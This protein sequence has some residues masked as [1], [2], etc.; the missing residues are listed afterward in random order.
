MNEIAWNWSINSLQA[1]RSQR[2]LGGTAN[3]HPL[4]GQR[5]GSRQPAS[6]LRRQVKNNVPAFRVTGSTSCVCSLKL[7]VP[8]GNNIL[9]LVYSA[10]PNMFD[11]RSA[12][13]FV[14]VAPPRCL[15]FVFLPTNFDETCVEL[16]QVTFG[17][18]LALPNWLHSQLGH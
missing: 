18:T 16:I 6:R 8:F 9:P 13:R 12:T 1:R 2:K 5:W 4:R 14:E 15:L 17:Y 7:N 11:A 10:C 3:K